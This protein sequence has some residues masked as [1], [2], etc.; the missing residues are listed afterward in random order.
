MKNGGGFWV[1][2]VR[3]FSLFSK[4]RILGLFVKLDGSALISGFIIPI[5][6]IIT[7]LSITLAATYWVMPSTSARSLLLKRA[8]ICSL[9][10]LITFIV[11][12]FLVYLYLDNSLIQIQL[13]LSQTQAALNASETALST[14]FVAITNVAATSTALA[15]TPTPT[16]YT[17]EMVRTAVQGTLEARITPRP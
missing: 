13:G 11:T 4:I 17:D 6:Q 8:T 16:R 7:T 1:S 5:L 2:A 15:L 10:V 14:S 3:H 12:C 9:I